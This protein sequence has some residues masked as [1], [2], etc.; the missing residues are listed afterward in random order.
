[1]PDDA[2]TRTWAHPQDAAGFARQWVTEIRAARNL[3]NHVGQQRY[4]EIRYED[5]VANSGQVVRSVCDFASLPFDPSMLEQGDVELAAKPHHRRLLEA[6][7]KR[8]DWSVEMS[9]ADAESFERAVGP[10]LAGLGYPLSNRNARRRNRRAAA[11][12][13]W[14]RARIAA[15]KTVAALNQRSPL[16]RRRHP[17]LDGL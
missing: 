10:L 3:G 14:Y 2:P 4:L 9:A 6:P 15:W 11:S 1:M 13:A 12:L 5:L 17:P 7:S 8:R 16:W